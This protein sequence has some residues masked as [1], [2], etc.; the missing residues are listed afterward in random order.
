MAHQGAQFHVQ[1][2]GE[3]TN[4]DNRPTERS[5][6]SQLSGIMQGASPIMGHNTFQDLLESRFEPQ[7]T[8]NSDRLGSDGSV[9]FETMDFG[10]GSYNELQ[11]LLLDETSPG[12]RYF[13][14][15][16]QTQAI[17]HP[18]S[19][20]RHAMVSEAG[21]PPLDF[22]I[23]GKEGVHG[24]YFGLSG[25]TD[26]Y[27][28]RHYRY[29]NN[30]EFRQFKLIFRQTS[31]DLYNDIPIDPPPDHALDPLLNVNDFAATQSPI[32]VHFM[33]A[34]DELSDDAKEDTTVRPHVSPEAVRLELDQIVKPDD[35]IRLVGLYV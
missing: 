35:G 31:N 16:P 7:K 24:L 15:S 4:Y 2:V 14:T 25:E 5:Q 13:G 17:E 27:L 22:P 1:G 26:P 9:N 10:N 3:A 20:K 32:P 21:V 19:R 30:G 29:D 23:D 6:S 34:A 12:D 11:D 28:L 18:E 8:L 33:M